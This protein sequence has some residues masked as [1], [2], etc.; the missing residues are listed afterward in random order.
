MNEKSSNKKTNPGKGKRI[1]LWAVIVF[2]AVVLLALVLL[3]WG[4]SLSEEQSQE[5]TPAVTEPAQIADGITA[6]ITGIRDV[7][8]TLDHG[9][10][11]I[12]IG[13]YTGAYV[14]DGSDEV[15]S[16]I[17]MLIVKNNGEEAIEYAQI[18]LPTD[19]GT[20]Q[21]NA[22]TL[23]PGATMVLLEQNRMA[24]TGQEQADQA[25]AEAVAVFKQPVGMHEDQLQ[26]QVLDGAINVT[27]ISGA[28]IT[29]DILIYYKNAAAD[30]YYGGI[31]YR[32][33]IEGGMKAGEI[34]QIMASHFT[35]SGSQ[36]MFVAIN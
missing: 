2:L 11:I 5:T 22:S 3:W 21:F 31:T 8:V 16:G 24:Y 1:A 36:I 9:I 15:V 7:A 18:A 23:L 12:N 33:R 14:E 25:V 20:A 26:L 32:V 6:N 17:L 4:L 13:A 27:N 35:A 19:N 10:E 34:K 28:D 29:G 30:L